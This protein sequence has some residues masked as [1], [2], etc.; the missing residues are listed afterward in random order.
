MS[1]A[2]EAIKQ[3][4]LSAVEEGMPAG[5]MFGTVVSAS[6]L[7]ISVE[8]KMTLDASL[9]ILTTLVRDFDVEMTVAHQTE[10]ALGGIDLTHAH[11]TPDGMSGDAGEKDLTHVHDYKGKKSFK[12]HLGLKE[13]E[14]VILLRVQGGQQFI[15]LDRVR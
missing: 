13:G 10:K 7:E 3:A 8:Q 6:P 15:V 1:D 2:I 5:V 14:R 4:A 11:S 9:L 12:V